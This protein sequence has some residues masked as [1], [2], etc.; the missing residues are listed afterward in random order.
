MYVHTFLIVGS[1]TRLLFR[2]DVSEKKE[3]EECKFPRKLVKFVS[4]CMFVFKN[5]QNEFTS[6]VE[7]LIC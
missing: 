3:N 1:L 2:M 6:F 5:I 4:L 7:H